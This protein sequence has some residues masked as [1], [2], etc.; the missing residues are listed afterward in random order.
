MQSHQTR[1]VIV[2]LTQLL[3]LQES[4]N[5]EIFKGVSA[6]A[7]D[8]T[9]SDRSSLYLCTHGCQSLITKV[10]QG[11]QRD[12]IIRLGEGIAGMCAKTRTPIIENHVQSNPIFNHEID[13][14]SGYTTLRTIAVPIIDKDGALLGVIQVLNKPSDYTPEE[15]QTLQLIATMV[16]VLVTSIEHKKTLQEQ[17]FAKSYQLQ[18][19]NESLQAQVATQIEANRRQ[20]L[21]LFKQAKHA[22]MGEIMD[23][24]A[25]QWKQPLSVMSTYT[26]QLRFS[27][28]D[29]MSTNVIESFAKK[30]ERQIHH[31]TSTLNEFRS[32]FR[33]S[34][35][36]KPF[37]L[38]RATHKVL[39][40]I[41][42][43]L[44]K[45]SITVQTAIDSH[46]ELV[47]I[48]N[49]FKHVLI[50]LLNNAKDAFIENK[51]TH[52]RIMVRASDEKG[53]TVV[54]VEDNAG[55]ISA[56][57]L[58]HIFEANVTTKG[59][60]EGT[61]I[62]LYLSAMII[63]KMNGTITAR[64]ANGG[65]TFVMLFEDYTVEGEGAPK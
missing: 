11:M 34:K 41:G 30:F 16:S 28:P 26:M 7:S 50:N 4:D 8:I 17:L 62:G 57:V 56:A 36:P 60:G 43:D 20:E 54:E 29:E 55:G 25:H 47:G 40:L 61:G 13:K 64:T 52:R 49:E 21:L 22:S 39:E 14:T 31:L 2:E 48:E 9:H 65:S 3:Q 15:M 5:L 24:V 37:K 12:I 59:E 19:L 35:A 53:A 6:I 46:L 32:F 23:A 44:A 1:N 51:I 10:A 18:T 58:P 45:A 27:T 38:S 42:E 63:D 33:P